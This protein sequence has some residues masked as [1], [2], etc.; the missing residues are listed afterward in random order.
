MSQFFRNFPKIPYKFGDETDYNLMD[1]LTKYSDFFVNVK[2]QVSFMQYYTVLDGDR[3]DT[4]SYKLY[5]S[6]DYHWT[7]YLL[8][9]HL[10]ESGWPLSEHEIEVQLAKNF[11]YIAITSNC[12]DQGGDKLNSDVDDDNIGAI[13]LVGTEVTG[14]ETSHDAV[15]VERNID[16]GQFILQPLTSADTFIGDSFLRY[17][18][19]DG[20]QTLQIIEV[21]DQK[22]AVHHYEDSDG[23]WQDI[24]PFEITTRTP[25]GLTT[26]TLEDNFRN[27]NDELKQIKVLRRE[28]VKTITSEYFKSIKR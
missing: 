20:E 25:V 3:P 5:G 1:N 21:N 15:I 12:K 9:E 22:D 18:P 10:R 17:N 24:N 16:I 14:R 26:V 13:F 27:K 28:V 2:D 6:P 19:G 7:F 8:N 23:V 11:P 4:L